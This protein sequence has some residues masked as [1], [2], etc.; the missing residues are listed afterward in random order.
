[1]QH[2][3]IIASRTSAEA[4]QI[5]AAL[6]QTAIPAFQTA[7]DV[8]SHLNDADSA[9]LISTSLLEDETALGIT[10]KASIIAPTYTIIWARYAAKA[11]NLLRLYGSGCFHVLGPDELDLLSTLIPEPETADD[12][13]NELVLPPFFIDDDVS[14]LK[15]PSKAIARRLHVTFLGHQAM[16]SCM[17]AVQNISASDALSLACVAP[18]TPWSRD[19]LVRN[20]AEYTLWTPIFE[21]KI[22][23]ASVTLC[24]DFNMLSAL[25]PTTMHIVVCHGMI[26]AEEEAYLTH[27]HPATRVFIAISEGYTSRHGDSFDKTISPETFWDILISTLYAN[28]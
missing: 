14:S 23:P 8:L 6:H 21:P 22:A 26:T 1:M 19:Q 18:L 7:N 4:A 27:L 16:M 28:D 25:E 13:F 17:N 12:F 2:P 10:T 11:Q 5:R 9:I 24:S 3:V 15:D 20:F